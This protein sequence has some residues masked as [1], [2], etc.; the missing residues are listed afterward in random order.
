MERLLAR[1][2]RR[3]GGYA[4]PNLTAMVVAG[5]VAVFAM[6]LVRPAIIPALT[7]DLDA[8]RH[9][10]VWRLFTYLFIPRTMSPMWIFFSVTFVWYVGSTLEN[11]W[12]SFRFN[13][14]YLLGCAGTTVAAWLTTA[15]WLFRRRGWQ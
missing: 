4:V 3:L 15:G 11:H 12:G 2:E 1:L 7:L 10:Q 5:M 14:F 8:V 6:A 13:V 9:G